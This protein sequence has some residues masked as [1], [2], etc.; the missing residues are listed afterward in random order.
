MHFTSTRLFCLALSL[1]VVVGLAGCPAPW[2]CAPVAD[3]SANVTSGGAPLT[4]TFTDESQLGGSTETAWYWTFGDGA[5]STQQNPVHTYTAAGKYRVSL[6]VNTPGGRSARTRPHY[7][8][9][10]PSSDETLAEY[11]ISEEVVTT[12]ERTLVSV[13]PTGIEIEPWEVALYEENGYGQWTYGD[14]VD[15]GR[16]ALLEGYVENSGSVT[17]VARLLHFFS[18]AD[19]HITDQESPAQLIYMAQF[20][21]GIGANAISLYSGAMPYTVHV[22]DAA[23]QTANAIH[24]QT[25]LDFGIT[26]GDAVNSAGYNELRWY[27]DVMDGKNIYPYSGDRDDPV[28]GPYNDYQ[29]PFKATGLNAEIPWYQVLGNHDQH[30]MGS[31]PIDDYLREVYTGENVLQMGNVLLPGGIHARDYYMGVLDGRTEYAE[32]YGAGPVGDFPEP[33]RVVADENRRPVSS[34]EWMSAFLGTSSTPVGHGFTQENVDNDFA[35]YSFEPRSDVPIKVIVLDNTTKPDTPGINPETD[36]Y[37]YGTLDKKRYDWLVAELEEGTIN[38]KLMII[39]A[40][41]PL[42]VEPAGSPM[43]WWRESYV[44]EAAFIAKLQEYPNLML[45]IAGHRHRNMIT[46]F[47]SPDPESPEY[48]FW[49]VETVSLREFPQQFRTFEILRNSDNTISIL[50]TN[51]DPAVGEG[52]FAETSRSYA[53]AAAQLFGVPHDDSINAE[54]VIHLSPQ[55]QALIEDYGMPITD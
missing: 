24:E 2:F 26:L 39:A 1:F 54:L 47:E 41:V 34:K 3:F 22:L 11:P 51:V 45:W 18:L 29:D 27:I 6:T 12:R 49:G 42:G 28:P 50:A 32:I 53:I 19:V 7:I 35:C 44:T 4:L 23:I 52:S 55:M 5:T 48:G 16:M 15:L 14:G 25:P 37:G 31:K 36:V 46:P 21:S 17:N 13:A 9:V 33:P 43:G 10:S 30:W 40:H 8:H 38:N 20:P